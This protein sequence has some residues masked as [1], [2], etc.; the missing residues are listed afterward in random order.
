MNIISMKDFYSYY[1]LTICC[2]FFRIL[3][4][5]HFLLFMLPPAWVLGYKNILMTG[6]GICKEIPLNVYYA[7]YARL[8][9]DM[10]DINPSCSLLQDLGRF[11]L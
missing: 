7:R 6:T 4:L 9:P 1:L 3:I 2:V 11:W 10:M 8:T 5:F